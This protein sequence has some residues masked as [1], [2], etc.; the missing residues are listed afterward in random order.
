MATSRD[1]SPSKQR[2]NYPAWLYKLRRR[3]WTFI[4]DLLEEFGPWIKWL[5]FDALLTLIVG[6]IASRFEATRPIFEA[7]GWL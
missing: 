7:V 3:V 2:P 4:E 5:V 1:P 6:F